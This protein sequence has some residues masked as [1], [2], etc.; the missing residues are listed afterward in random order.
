MDITDKLGMYLVETDEVNEA[1]TAREKA[2]ADWNKI[3]KV[4]Q[5]IDNKNQVTTAK[6]MIKNFIK[7]H[8]RDNG[9]NL[10]ELELKSV[11]RKL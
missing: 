2:V 8:G 7:V 3:I 4:I 1:M 9:H 6:N 11:S 10:L 5:S